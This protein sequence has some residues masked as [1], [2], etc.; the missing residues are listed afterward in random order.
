[1]K[2]AADGQR[3]APSQA[4]ACLRRPPGGGASRTCQTNGMRAARSADAEGDSTTELRWTRAGPTRSTSRIVLRP[5][6]PQPASVLHAE[7]QL[8]GRPGE[9][10]SAVVCSKVAMPGQWKTSHPA[11]RW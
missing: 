6:R 4:I 5:E 10:H 1:M 7:G 11:R 8:S 3:P 9:V 2:M